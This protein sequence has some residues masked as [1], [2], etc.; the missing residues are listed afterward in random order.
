[1][2]SSLISK[3]CLRNLTLKQSIECLDVCDQQ[4]DLTT[5]R[6]LNM[7]NNKLRQTVE[8]LKKSND[9]KNHCDCCKKNDEIYDLCRK[10]IFLALC[11]AND[12][13]KLAFDSKSAHKILRIVTQ[14]QYET[15]LLNAAI[16]YFLEEF[17]NGK[18]GQTLIDVLCLRNRALRQNID[19]LR[20]DHKINL[21][22]FQKLIVENDKLKQAVELLKKSNATETRCN[23]KENNAAILDFGSQQVL[24]ALQIA[25]DV[26]QVISGGQTEV[27]LKVINAQQRN[28]F[29]LNQI[30]LYLLQEFSNS[31]VN[32]KGLVDFARPME[33]GAVEASF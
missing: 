11:T 22:I 33:S 15:H 9:T 4:T 27:V 1:M 8:F 10:E 18:D 6:N 30:A 5:L 32:C 21:I 29:V 16:L 17:D 3:L 14:Q 19:V 13:T 20:G 2:E 26:K 31:E 12:V 25:N 7:E 24:F 23:C 28:I